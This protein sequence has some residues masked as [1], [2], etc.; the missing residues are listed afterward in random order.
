V[1]F[2]ENLDPE[3][4]ELLTSVSRQVSYVHGATLVRHADP[5]RGAYVIREGEVE[6]VVT[7]PGG[8]SLTVARLG[9]GGMFGE[10]ALIELG[11]CTATVRAASNVDAWFIA[12]EDFRA[13]VSQRGAAALRLQHAVTMALAEKLAAINA[14]L[15]ATP[16]PED[17]AARKVSASDDPLAGI[18]R[19]RKA[20]F[21]TAGFLPRL[22]AFQH[23][24]LD[25]IDEAVAGTH[26]M[27]LPRGQ[28]V[29][30]SGGEARSAFVVVRGAVEIVAAEGERERR[31]A[32][33]GPGQLVGFLSV[34]AERAHSTHAFAR[35]SSLL[36][37]FEAAAFRD[38]YF[39]ASA[40]SARL[41]HAV[42]ASLL[43]SIARTNRSLTR[44][45]SQQKL[46]AAR[47]A[48]ELEA[49][50]H[51]QLATAF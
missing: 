2:L 44:L 40:A 21:D 39:G 35:E 1:S 28:A 22:P 42:Q 17:C 38:L 27:E 45:I 33:L 47:G 46:E 13:V 14:K 31:M 29:F 18:A 6:A 20:P 3:S 49:A 5:A 23:F 7:L 10:M 34:L 25:E 48:T 50:L 32:V 19:S 8:E 15:I 26:Y 41:R 4:R 16:A 36:L 24:S 12:H 11:T 37:E 43:A 30:V 9:A 51:G